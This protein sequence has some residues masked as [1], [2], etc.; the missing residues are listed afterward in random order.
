MDYDFPDDDDLMGMCIITLDKAAVNDPTPKRPEWYNLS[1][2]KKGSELGEIL[3]SF[4]LYDTKTIPSTPSLVPEVIDTTVEINV[5]GLRDLKPALGWLPV[6][7]PYV[8]FDLNSL[9][10]PD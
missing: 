1:M 4:N 6:N 10:I 3:V 2:G 5:L 8:K 7:K 9:Q